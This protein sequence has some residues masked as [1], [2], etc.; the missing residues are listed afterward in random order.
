MQDLAD[1]KKGITDDD[2]LALVNDDEVQQGFVMWQLRD[3]QVVC[4][5][6]GLPTAT[7]RLRGP[8]GLEK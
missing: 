8:D 2:L 5:T 3:L 7:V 1:K 6:M 4:G